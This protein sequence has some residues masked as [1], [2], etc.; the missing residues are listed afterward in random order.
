MKLFHA[1]Q[2]LSI[3]GTLLS[4]PFTVMPAAAVAVTDAPE[5]LRAEAPRSL[6]S[7]SSG[8]CLDVYSAGMA[9]GANVIQWTCNSQPNQ[10]WDLVISNSGYYTLR[11]A[12]SGKCLDVA[13]ASGADGANVVQWTCN[14]Q[15]N[16]QWRLVQKG[17]NYFSLVS[18]HSG[19]CLDVYSASM[20]DGANIVQWNC[21]SQYNQQWRFA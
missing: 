7:R 21:T 6:V 9:D 18:R 11:V 19:K 17:N 4:V 10:R 20:A 15:T 8:K 13:N 3:A 12:H 14:S 16:Q 5:R 2:A 1:V